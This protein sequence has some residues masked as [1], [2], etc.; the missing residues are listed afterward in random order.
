MRLLPVMFA[1]LIAGSFM[2]AIVAAIRH[3]T[4][5]LLFFVGVGW[6]NTALFIAWRQAYRKR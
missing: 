5:W 2:Q 6:I 3:E 1:F 4:D